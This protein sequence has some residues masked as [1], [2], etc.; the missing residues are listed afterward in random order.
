M[1]HDG[2][3]RDWSFGL[4]QGAALVTTVALGVAILI[5]QLGDGPSGFSAPPW[6]WW[7]AY[8]LFVG[9]Q[10]L[11]G[12]PR[13]ELWLAAECTLAAAVYLL[14]PGWT[15][16]AILLVSTA[17]AAAFVLSTPAALAVVGAQ[18]AVIVVGEL[19]LPADEVL[20]MAAIY[21]GFQLFAVFTA[22]TATREIRMRT[23]LAETNRELRDAQDLLRSSAQAGERLRISRELH[24]LVGHQLT[25]L[26]LELEVAAHH[27]DGDAARH[28]DRA[29]RTAKEL[30][31]D[32]RRAVGRL[33]TAP[34]DVSAAFGS[35]T[36]IA[37]PEVHLDIDDDMEFADPERAQALVRCVQEIV[38]NTVRHAGA[39][40][41]WITVGR[42]GD[43]VAVDA[44]DDGRGATAVRPGNGL[45]GMRE[46]L[47][48]LGGTLAYETGPGGGFTLRARLPAS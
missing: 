8:G 17:A 40:H 24:D 14:A 21:G 19:G 30:L 5:W 47:E 33:R 23:E 28:V 44:T 11:D 16:T 37:K 43:E 46:R 26:A 35:V 25:A 1:A 29:R 13:A 18:T 3:V 2:P 39:D 4:R 12:W 10:L 20:T 15:L 9:V 42:D 7:T 32:V 41:L 45:T 22:A 36:G 6:L 31:T 34:G 27:T 38:T 48:Q